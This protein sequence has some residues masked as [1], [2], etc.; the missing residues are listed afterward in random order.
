[1]KIRSQLKGSDGGGAAEVEDDSAREA[2]RSVAAAPAECVGDLV[3][4]WLSGDFVMA[5]E[6]IVILYNQMYNKMSNTNQS[7]F[8][9]SRRLKSC[10]MVSQIGRA[11]V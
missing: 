3:P 10:T 5:G 6:V 1:M 7:F 9:N 2:G 8:L 11:H 4:F